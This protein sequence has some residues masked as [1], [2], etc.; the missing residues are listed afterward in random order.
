MIPL[1]VPPGWEQAHD[2]QVRCQRLAI[3]D[4]TPEGCGERDRNPMYQ[5]YDCFT[6]FSHRG[7]WQAQ[8]SHALEPLRVGEEARALT[9][10]NRAAMVAEPGERIVKFVGSVSAKVGRPSVQPVHSR[11][12]DGRL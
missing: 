7:N 12:A 5:S 11:N 1:P 6:Y 9:P 4:F 10:V 3:G 8:A 2:R